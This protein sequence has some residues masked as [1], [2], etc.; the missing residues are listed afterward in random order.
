M[1]SDIITALKSGSDTAA[2]ANKKFGDAILKN[3]CDNITIT[4]GW[5]AVS[6]PPASSPDPVITFTA[7]VSG[8]GTLSPSN[9]FPL[10]LVKLAALIKGL[11]IT[12]SAGFA[13]APLTFN[14]AAVLTVVMANEDTQ[15]AAMEHFCAQII[16]S[17]ISTFPNPAPAA[18]THGA[19]TG[20]TTG[21][22]IL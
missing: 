2:N 14:P 22:V 5:A 4:Y 7:T 12:A 1:K 8:G 6:P 3:I 10:M 21:M 17:V 13:V 16:A 19:F 11:T 9:S 15:N 20:A 18:G